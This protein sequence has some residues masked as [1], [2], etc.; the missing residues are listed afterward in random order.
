MSI[1]SKGHFLTLAQGSVHTKIQT[2]FFRNYSAELN[3]L[4]MKVSRY[5]EM[6]IRLYDAGHMTKMATT[7]I[8]GKKPS[9]FISGTDGIIYPKLGM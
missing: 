2:G 3:Q 6:T 1:E 8:Y 4:C 5:K 7:P 9:K